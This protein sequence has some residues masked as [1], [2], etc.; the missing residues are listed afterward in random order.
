MRVVLKT[1]VLL[2]L[3]SLPVRAEAAYLNPT[4]VAND[5]QPNG[6]TRLVLQFA[7]NAGE[8]IVTREFTVV[9]S[10]TATT[11]RN[12]VHAVIAELDLMHATASLP[13]LQ[14]GQ[15]VPAL[16]PSAVTP[17]PKSRC[18]HKIALYDQLDGKGYTGTLADAI[19]ALKADIEATCT[20]S[21]LEP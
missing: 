7:G 10:T 1:V 12:W 6:A 3:I 2:L 18:R 8:P 9:A 13:A 17:S 4:V 5:R 19:T 15:T 20:A 16:A 14:P 11:F 21:H